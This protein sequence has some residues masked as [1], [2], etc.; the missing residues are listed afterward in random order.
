MDLFWKPLSW[1]GTLRPSSAT[2]AFDLPLW[3]T[4]FTSAIGLEVP[5][6]ASL[7]R[8]SPLAKCGRKKTRM[9]FHGDHT[10]TCTAHSGATKAH[11]WMVSA[12]GPLF[13][14]AAHII[15]LRSA[16]SI[17]IGNNA[18]NQNIS[19]LPAI[20]STS[21]R[22]HDEFSRLL[23]LQAHRETEAHFTATG[24]DSFRFKRAAFYQSLKSKVG[25]R[26]PMRRR[27]GSTSMSRAVA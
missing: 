25:S 14:T 8:N 24:S 15:L 20:L 11:E 17:A 3:E 19:L 6:L 26:Q 9:D 16:R 12:L 2:D 13:R 18:D 5:E 1:L 4:F 22:M 7:P 10:S 23:F 27:Y 21:T